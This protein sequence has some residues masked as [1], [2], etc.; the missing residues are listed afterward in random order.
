[1]IYDALVS[2]DLP[3]ELGAPL[4]TSTLDAIENL[5]FVGHW[6]RRRASCPLSAAVV[7]ARCHRVLSAL[8][9][10]G[11]TVL[12]DAGSVL[13]QNIPASLGDG[14][15]ARWPESLPPSWQEQPCDLLL[16]ASLAEGGV[17]AAVTLRYTPRHDPEQGALSGA[18]RALWDV[19]P[20]AGDEQAFQLSF[21]AALAD[22]RSLRELARRMRDRGDQLTRELVQGLEEAF[23]AGPCHSHGR[24][25]ALH[26]YRRQPQR[27]GELLAGLPDPQRLALALLEERL[28]QSLTRWPALDA[29]G[30][31]GRLHRGRF[32]PTAEVAHVA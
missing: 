28:A 20:R 13:A 18:V 9:C 21:D 22:E 5:L 17:T 12:D 29:H 10:R 14:P 31:P 15:E 19:Q 6:K 32:V 4:P 25:L 11:L 27:F 8:G 26:G 24:V 16:R 30:V 23:D 7:L 2:L 1:M 3:T